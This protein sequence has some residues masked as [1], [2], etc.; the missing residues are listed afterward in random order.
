[1]NK[2]VPY[3]HY[4]TDNGITLPNYTVPMPYSSAISHLRTI[5]LGCHLCMTP[6]GKLEK[7]CLE[8][9]DNGHP[10]LSN[11]HL[12]SDEEIY[13]WLLQFKPI[14]SL[15]KKSVNK[16]YPPKRWDLKEG[17]A[18]YSWLPLTQSQINWIQSL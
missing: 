9:E 16:D 7:D 11:F 1:M 6:T 13:N 17:K 12:L 8:N 18:V 2:P 14:V 10:Y 15:Q 3:S 4:K 5:G